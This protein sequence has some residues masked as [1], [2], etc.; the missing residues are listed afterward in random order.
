M[1]PQVRRD[2]EEDGL[3]RRST[4]GWQDDTRQG[5]DR[6]ESWISELGCRR[7]SRT[8][9][10]HGSFPRRGC[11]YSM[12]CTNTEAGETISRGCSITAARGSKFWSR[13]ARVWTSTGSAA[14]HC[15]DVSPFAPASTVGCRVGAH[16]TRRAPEPSQAG[17]FS[18]PFFSGSETEARR[19]S[20]EHRTLLIREEVATLERVQDLGNLELLMLRLPELV[21][22]PLSIN[23]LREDSSSA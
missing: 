13:E 20:R 12:N 15:R 8:D 11:E 16:D 9:P 19:W 4:P 23:A 22:S 6:C 14:T 2:L 3:C 7:T 17:R 21:G 1:A 18:Q 10:F 5:P